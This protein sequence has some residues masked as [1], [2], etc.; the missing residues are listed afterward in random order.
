MICF[1][2]QKSRD[3]F[4]V[5]EKG[6]FSK[7][8][9]CRKIQAKDYCG[10]MT[11][12]IGGFLD[13]NIICIKNEHFSIQCFLGKSQNDVYDIELCNILYGLEDSDYCA[14]ALLYGDDLICISRNDSKVYY[15]NASSREMQII[16][17]DFTSFLDLI[18]MGAPL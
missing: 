8:L 6:F 10:W 2:R 18:I 9:E 3:F 15:F 1:D 5:P 11:T 14:I 4:E 13:E 16:C 7:Y 12:A 17:D